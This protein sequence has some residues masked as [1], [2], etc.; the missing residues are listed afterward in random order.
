[1][2]QPNRPRPPEPG[3]E[4]ARDPGEGTIRRP[5]NE[6]VSLATVPSLTDQAD[7]SD[8]DTVRDPHETVRGV[9]ASPLDPSR[10]AEIWSSLLANL[11]EHQAYAAEM[12]CGL[13]VMTLSRYASDRCTSE[14]RRLVE[15]ASQKSEAV[16]ECLALVAVAMSES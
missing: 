14:E 7:K 3:G 15:A 10:E 11:K 16:R 9:P 5:P 1:M 6:S 12:W 4:P 13:D 8:S 2:A